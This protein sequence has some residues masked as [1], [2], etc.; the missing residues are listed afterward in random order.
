MVSI[1]VLA[2]GQ[3][4]RMGQD[5]AFLAVGGQPVIERVLD[6]VR[7]LTDDLF[8]STNSPE[9]YQGYGLRLVGDIYP[10]KA[11]LGGLYTAIHAAQHHHVLVVACDMPFLNTDLLRHLIDLAGSADVIAPL[12]NPPQPETMHAVYSKACLEPIERRLLQ[13]RLKIIG[14]FEDV[15]V[16]YLEAAE[17]AAFDPDFHAFINMN[18]PAD[19]TRVQTIAEQLS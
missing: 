16:R 17:I 3:S 4:K 10:D 12:I 11:A 13:N 7:P 18:T 5:K 14:F 19:W 1:A 2:G 8:I 9:K 6:R 15:A